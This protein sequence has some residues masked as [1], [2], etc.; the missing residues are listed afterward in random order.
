MPYTVIPSSGAASRVTV[1]LTGAEKPVYVQGREQHEQYAPTTKRRLYCSGPHSCSRSQPR[2]LY[3][4]DS[5]GKSQS[6]LVKVIVVTVS[7]LARLYCGAGADCVITVSTSLE[8]LFSRPAAMVRGLTHSRATP[9][10]EPRRAPLRL[11]QRCATAWHRT[12]RRPR[13]PPLINPL[14]NPAHTPLGPSR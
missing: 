9:L 12:L 1:A 6:R 7:K 2:S 10:G 5:L 3:S 13:L 14:I 8:R 11:A 4:D